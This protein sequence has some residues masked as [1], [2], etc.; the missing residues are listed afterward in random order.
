MLAALSPEELVE[1]FAAYRV[2]PLGDSWKQTGVVAATIN[3][4]FEQYM[5]GKAGKRRVD[6]DRWRVPDD[7]I[8]RMK[9]KKP[10]TP[11]VNRASIDVYQ[12]MIESQYRGVVN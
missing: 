5:A 7:F 10:E 4:K 11:K 2:I 9:P 3:N 6:K 8:P 1:A 12:R